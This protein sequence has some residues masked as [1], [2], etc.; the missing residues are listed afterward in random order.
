MEYSLKLV[1]S[2][3]ANR[4]KIARDWSVKTLASYTVPY[5]VLRNCVANEVLVKFRLLTDRQTDVL[6]EVSEKIGEGAGN[7]IRFL[8]K[9]HTRD[10][11]RY[12]I[13]AD[14]A[15]V[16]PEFAIAP[17]VPVRLAPIPVMQLS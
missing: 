3:R 15:D 2:Q 4:P 1:A 6:R 11:L 14:I 13:K 5:A 17:L 8:P 12:S 7:R 10:Q 16:R 9:T